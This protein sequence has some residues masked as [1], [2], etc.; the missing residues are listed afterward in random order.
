MR[1]RARHVGI[2]VFA[3]L[4]FSCL[5]VTSARAQCTLS[6][7]VTTWTDGNSNWLNAGN[8]NTGVPNSST[9]GCITDGTSTVTLDANQSLN[10][11][12]LQIGSGNTLTSGLNVDLFVY[13]TQIINNGQIL[14]NGGG[15]TNTVL[16]LNAN[17][18]L[19]G[20]GTVTLSTAGGGGNAFIDQAAGGLTLNNVDNTIQGAGIIG[21]NGL[22]VVNGA[23]GTILANAPDQTLLFNGGGT[24]TNNGTFQANAGSALALTNVGFTNFAGSTLAGGT[25]KIFGTV[26]SPGTLE[27]NALGN[28]GGEI[29]NNAATILLDG[30]NSNFVDMAGLDALSNFSNNTAAGS[31]TIQNGRNFTSASTG[32]SS[33][34]TVTIGP[35]SAF[36]VGGPHDY[37]QSGG[38]TS[39]TSSTSTLAVA[40]GHSVTLNGGTLNGSG[41]IQ[42]NLVNSGLVLPGLP[43]KAGI[44]TVTGNYTESPASTLSLQLGGPTAGI[45]F[46]QLSV[47]GTAMLKGTLDV[48]LING[49][50]PS[51][52]EQFV[53]L[54]ST[55]LS[56]SFT[57]NVINDGGVIFNV[58]YSPVGFSNDVVLNT[59]AVPEPAS[60]ALVA[61]GLVGVGWK[62][63]RTPSC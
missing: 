20:G 61:L 17:T 22:S 5:G 16:G 43:G 50:A 33:S 32:F 26:P 51:V 6:G 3:A 27:I 7:T 25:Y 14:L 44:L 46:S 10:T 4:V 15:G 42:G 2:G 24:V 37:V 62:A 1:E 39:L 48:P 35:N 34:G 8:W 30:P 41:T 18:T 28:T 38:T 60:L 53:I 19:Q 13:G 11:L 47:L 49:F 29:V 36:T 57:D 31:F 52:G 55:G 56:G 59:T 58:S 40:S 21:Q 12:D 63:R 9:S 45:N 54:T 23:A